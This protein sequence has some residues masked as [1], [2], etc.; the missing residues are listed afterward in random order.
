MVTYSNEYF[1]LKHFLDITIKP[2]LV[3]YKTIDHLY[4]I[5][6]IF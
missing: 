2:K 5:I 3:R 1:Y 6:T 4:G